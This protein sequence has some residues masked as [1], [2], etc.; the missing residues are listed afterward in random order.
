MNANV[1]LVDGPP[2]NRRFVRGVLERAGYEVKEALSMDRAVEMARSNP[3]LAILVEAPPRTESTERFLHRLRC[4]QNTMTVPVMVLSRD[5]KEA[6]TDE[7]KVRISRL[8]EESSPLRLL[9]ELAFLTR[10]E[11]EMAP[12][13]GVAG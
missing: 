3:P 11:P 7:E 12:P 1:L 10:P 2:E 8:N 4:H 5:D 9:E 13:F 6:S